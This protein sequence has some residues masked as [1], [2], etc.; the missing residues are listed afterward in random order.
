MGI[1]TVLAGVLLVL[2]QLGYA[3]I[4]DVFILWPVM[5]ILLGLETIISKFIA[6]IGKNKQELS[7]AWGIIIICTM[8]IAGSQVWMM[9]IDSAYYI[10]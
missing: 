7:P 6:S 9:L 3:V 2:A 10:W 1:S 4:E 5:L 8:L